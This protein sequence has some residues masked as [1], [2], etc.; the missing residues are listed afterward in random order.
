MVGRSLPMTIADKNVKLSIVDI[1]TDSIATVNIPCK[2]ESDE[3]NSETA[4]ERFTNQGVLG[5]IPRK[6][7]FWTLIYS[8]SKEESEKIKNFEERRCFWFDARRLG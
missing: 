8:V 7:N 4:F 3:Y 6:E 1:T 2:I 5:L